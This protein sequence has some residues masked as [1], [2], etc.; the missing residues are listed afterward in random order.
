MLRHTI[1]SAIGFALF[2]V[3]IEKVVEHVSEE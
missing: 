3:V 1:K 2:A